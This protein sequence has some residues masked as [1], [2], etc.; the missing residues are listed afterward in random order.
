[1]IRDIIDSNITIIKGKEESVIYD[2]EL[3]DE[4]MQLRELVAD[5]KAIEPSVNHLKEKIAERAKS[6]MDEGGTITFIANG[7][8]IK[9]TFGYSCIIP[10]EKLEK[11]KEIL[12]DRFEDLVKIKTAIS[13]TSKLI[14]IASDDKKKH[15]IRDLLIIKENAPKFSFDFNA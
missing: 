10:E 9:I 2:P 14:E 13:G 7:H 6:L 8:P 3:A 1:M 11:V 15:P 12:G 4:L 5:I